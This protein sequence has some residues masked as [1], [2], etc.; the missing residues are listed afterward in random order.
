VGGPP[1][2][3]QLVTR[4]PRTEHPRA[5]EHRGYHREYDARHRD[6]L[7]MLPGNSA[8]RLER[9]SDA[10]RGELSHDSNA[11]RHAASLVARGMVCAG[12]VD[13]NRV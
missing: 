9:L 5:D 1:P 6:R 8:A 7:A 10:P 12:L 11:R 4:A 13:G 2:S 3:G